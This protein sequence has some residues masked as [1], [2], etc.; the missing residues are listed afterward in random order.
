MRDLTNFFLWRKTWT[1]I[2]L[3]FLMASSAFSWPAVSDIRIFWS[4]CAAIVS[5]IILFGIAL[6]DWKVSAE[7]EAD[8]AEFQEQVQQ[9][10]RRINRLETAL[11]RA[12]E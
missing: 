8:Y 11:Q 6:Y 3:V 4:V 12:A 2:A 7:E 10:E 5:T 1:L 9:M